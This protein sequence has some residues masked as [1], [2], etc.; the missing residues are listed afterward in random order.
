MDRGDSGLGRRIAERD[1]DEVIFAPAFRRL[2]RKAQVFPMLRDDSAH[3]R[4]FHS[5]EC[6]SVGRSLGREAAS[7]LP[8]PSG[9]CPGDIA[10][11]VAT[12]ALTHDI[13][14]PP[15]GHSGEKAIQAAFAADLDWYSDLDIDKATLAELRNIDGNAIGLHMLLR[16]LSLAPTT[17]MSAAKR[18]WTVNRDR[19]Y[20]IL[21]ED[22]D[23]FARIAAAAGV[24]RVSEHEWNRHALSY[25][26][27]AADDICYVIMDAIDAVHLGVITEEQCR[28][29]LE[30]IS[31]TSGLPLDKLRDQV[32]ALLVKAASDAFQNNQVP[33]L[34]GEF[35]GS[36][37]DTMDSHLSKALEQLRKFEVNEVYTHEP[38]V[39][40]E[41]AGFEILRTLVEAFSR[42]VVTPRPS[43]KD[44]RLYSLLSAKTRLRL[45]EAPSAGARV[46]E[47]VCF[48]A[49]MTDRYAFDSCQTLR[50]VRLPHLLP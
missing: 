6:A 39:Q 3:N 34:A 46:V 29:H 41:V 20:C 50:G 1:Y 14:N 23:R 44:K 10:A 19:K 21:T 28:H 7:S 18:P 12:A 47:A 35:K 36:L 48:V 37:V 32:L 26:M 24:E 15:F 17:V 27:E 22:L 25:L 42:A 30:K 13:G 43:A 38:V 40:L 4:L 11:T 31:N 5:L 16:D 9:V 49:G 45:E 2:A 8:L 33:I